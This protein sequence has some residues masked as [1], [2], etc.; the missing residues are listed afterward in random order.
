MVLPAFLDEGIG[1][2]WVGRGRRPRRAGWAGAGASARSGGEGPRPCLGQLLPGL[3]FLAYLPGALGPAPTSFGK[4]TQEA[5]THCLPS[6][7]DGETVGPFFPQPGKGPH[8]GP[9]HSTLCSG[10]SARKAQLPSYPLES[11]ISL[12]LS[13]T[14]TMGNLLPA[15]SSTAP[16]PHQ[17]RSLCSRGRRVGG[18]HSC[19]LPVMGGETVTPANLPRDPQVGSFDVWL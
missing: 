7:E 10:V 1:P 15:A 5:L 14:G 9:S 16:P 8:L 6:Q 13:E 19:H 18:T 2:C 17:T 3:P 12:S 4:H 11:A